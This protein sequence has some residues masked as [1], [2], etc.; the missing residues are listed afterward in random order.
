MFNKILVAIDKSPANQEVLHKAIN[1]AKDNNSNLMLLHVISVEEQG[2]PMPYIPSMSQ[3]YPAT[4]NELTIEVWQQQWEEFQREGLE[5]LQSCAAEAK[6]LDIKVEYRQISGSPSRS[7]CSTAREWGADTIVI[8]RRGR[9]GL[10]EMLL[11]SVSN[12]VVHHAPCSVLIVQENK[13]N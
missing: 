4:G 5:M 8:G 1:L 3:Y 11:G 9:S 10:S 2:S 7:I 12:Y 13:K 6:K